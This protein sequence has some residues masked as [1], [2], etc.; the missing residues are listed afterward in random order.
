MRRA[1]AGLMV[2]ALAAFVGAGCSDDNSGDEAVED[3]IE[4]AAGGDVEIGDVPGDFPKGVPLPEGDVI[5]A[6][7]Q[8][9]GEN[10]S[11]S[12]TYEV[13]D[14]EGAA[15]SYRGKLEDEGFDVEDT[16]ESADKTGSVSSFTASNGDFDVNVIGASGQETSLSV[17]V[18]QT[19]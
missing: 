10:R 7:S 18:A 15:D 17:S 5:T 4:D 12:V 3:A 19:L 8:G 16:F 2:G 11:W 13:G 9:D 6:G 1:L 14:L